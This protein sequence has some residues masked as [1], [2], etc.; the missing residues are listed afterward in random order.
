MERLPFVRTLRV[1]AGQAI[2]MRFRLDP[3][4]GLA[5]QPLLSLGAN[6]SLGQY[7]VRPLP[8]PF[9]RLRYRSPD[10]ETTE[11]APLADPPGLVHELEIVPGYADTARPQA[12]A[13]ATLDGLPVSS[14]AGFVAY[15]ECPAT[16]GID[17][18]AEPGTGQFFAGPE[19]G[20]EVLPPGEPPQPPPWTGKQL[21]IVRFPSDMAGS[22]PL[23]VSGVTGAGDFVYVKY[24]GA[25]Q[26]RFGFDHWGV[27]GSVGEPVAFD[28]RQLHR[29]EIETGAL[30]PSSAEQAAGRVTVK[31]DGA[32][33]LDGM[34]PIHPSTQGQIYVGRNP[35][36]GSTAQPL[37]HGEILVSRPLH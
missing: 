13:R 7:S 34:S 35:I 28:P 21:L 15:S 18:L 2:R 10:G 23:V 6:G 33:V 16:L 11:S 9:L 14:P 5:D 17:P 29:L 27:G 22:E 1:L 19:L 30:I 36:G 3:D 24:V 12:C 31:L 8:G 37:F 32:T 25:N 20:A 26:L 4:A